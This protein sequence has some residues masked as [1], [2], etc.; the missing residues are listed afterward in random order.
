MCCSPWGLKE[1]DTTWWLNNNNWYLSSL[2]HSSC[3][4]P[5]WSVLYIFFDVSLSS[6]DEIQAP[7][8][9]WKLPRFQVNSYIICIFSSKCLASTLVPKKSTVVSFASHTVILEVLIITK[10]RTESW[11]SWEQWQAWPWAQHGSPVF[12]DNRWMCDKLFSAGWP[13]TPESHAGSWKPSFEKCRKVSGDWRCGAVSPLDPPRK[14][15]PW[16]HTVG[17]PFPWADSARIEVNIFKWDNTARVILSY[18]LVYWFSER[19]PGGGD[20]PT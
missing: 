2:A 1:S 8:S 5:T 12:T 18:K 15:A 19:R 3:R 9:P 7:I 14:S 17:C 16:S 11:P 20:L 10:I 6:G 4:L 13:L